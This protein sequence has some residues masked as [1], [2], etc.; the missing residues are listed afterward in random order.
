MSTYNIPIMSGLRIPND[1]DENYKNLTEEQ[2]IELGKLYLLHSK[3]IEVDCQT[4]VDGQPVKTSAGL[5]DVLGQ[6]SKTTGVIQWNSNGLNRVKPDERLYPEFDID[7]NLANKINTALEAED[8]TGQVAAAVTTA[9]ASQDISGQ[10]SFLQNQLIEI[11]SATTSVNSTLSTLQDTV[12]SAATDIN[13]LSTTLTLVKTQADDLNTNINNI[14]CKI[15]NLYN[16]NYLD[17]SNFENPINQRAHLMVNNNSYESTIQSIYSIDRWFLSP[18]SV[19]VINDDNI[20]ITGTLSQR[21]LLSNINASNWRIFATKIVNNE[22]VTKDLLIDITTGNNNFENEDISAH[23]NG[24][25]II[26]SLKTGKWKNIGLYENLQSLSLNNWIYAPKAFNDELL[27]CMKY[28]YHYEGRSQIII[29]GTNIL[30]IYGYIPI[31]MRIIPSIVGINIL[32]HIKFRSSQIGV[33]AP[34]ASTGYLDNSENGLNQ[35]NYDINLADYL[36]LT[37]NTTLFN[38]STSLGQFSIAVGYDAI[39]YPANE[40]RKLW[41]NGS[42][43]AWNDTAN[44]RNGFTQLSVITTQVEENGEMVNKSVGQWYNTPSIKQDFGGACYISIDFSADLAM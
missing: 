41:Y 26:V 10:I 7:G 9:I 43:F 19:L 1:T 3:N 31:Q 27:N 22:P 40:T 38:T 15:D 6:L 17:N 39:Q 11:S 13:N 20:E 35:F 23:I 8:I 16:Y 30:N 24:T 2:K 18:N 12:S 37:Y 14:Q 5:S 32:R 29:E 36:N 28:F 42:G 34:V 44:V 33:L 25:E 21:V 4:V